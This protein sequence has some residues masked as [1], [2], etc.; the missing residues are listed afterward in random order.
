MQPQDVT[1][2]PNKPAPGQKGVF[3]RVVLPLLLIVLI[4][5][6]FAWVAQYL[7]TQ[8]KFT[9]P[10]AG[11]PLLE[12]VHTTAR[13]VSVEAPNPDS[14]TIESKPVFDP[15]FKEFERET[16][17]QYDFLFQNVA[18]SEVEIGLESIS[19]DCGSV[20][21]CVL[22]TAQWEQL[23][24]F[25]KDQPGEPLSYDSKTTW[26]ELSANPVKKKTLMLKPDDHGVVRVKW[27]ARAKN[28]GQELNLRPTVWSH[29]VGGP[30]QRTRYE[31]RV[32][33]VVTAKVRFFPPRVNIGVLTP[34][35]TKE[36][37]FEAWSPTLEK[38]NLKLTGAKPDPFFDVK[39][40][41]LS[42]KECEELE[43]RLHAELIRSRVKSAQ[44]I[45]VTVHEEKDGKQM[46]QEEF[47]RR[48]PV[49]LDDSPVPL[50]REDLQDPGPEIFGVVRGEVE[51]GGRDDKG[52]IRFKS[53][54]S[55]EGATK[56][57]ELA[58]D[59][60]THLELKTWHPETLEVELTRKE[61]KSTLKGYWRL[62]VTVPP[63]TVSGSFADTDGVT[64]RIRESS[65][66]VRIPLEGNVSGQ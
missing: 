45:I 18:G 22:P 50:D 25:Q 7:K 26:H 63:G 14:K 40:V 47:L 38:L 37:K 32:P 2:A 24:K 31:L 4:I 19:C 42:P 48:F 59:P 52:R 62:K 57:I 20:E 55:R 27:R 43:S 11:K 46:D 28:L 35:S 36:A 56:E 34:R 21:V 8:R 15:N 3:T 54:L 13:W 6:S 44:R 1:S 66:L 10:P 30:P 51:V 9:P 39:I 53:F 5:G 61:T 58:C 23:K 33:G 17:G 49:F 60:K 29:L 41:T 12:F 64:L 65:R 16:P